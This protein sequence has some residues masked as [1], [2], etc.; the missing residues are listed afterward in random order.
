M[1]IIYFDALKKNLRNL[2]ES[3]QDIISKVLCNFCK[4]NDKFIEKSFFV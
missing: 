4:K 2:I 3:H 1:M